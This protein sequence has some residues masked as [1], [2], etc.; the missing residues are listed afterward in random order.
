MNLKNRLSS[1]S[2]SPPSRKKSVRLLIETGDGRS[3]SALLESGFLKH[4]LNLGA[5]IHVLTPGANHRPFVESYQ[6][7]GVRFSYLSVERAIAVR[8]PKLSRHE[9]HLARWFMMHGMRGVQ[10]WLWRHAGSRIAAAD[11]DFLRELVDEESPDCF[12]TAHLNQGF[13]RSLLGLCTRKGIPTVGN[14]FSWD[15]PFYPQ[16]VQ[17]DRLTCWSPVIRDKLVQFGG[18]SPESI[19]VTG[20]P[21]FDPYFDPKG[22]LTRQELCARMNLDPSRPIILFATLGQMRMFWDETGTFRAF[23]DALDQARIPG[24][25]QIILRLHPISVDHYFEEFR[26]RPDVVFSRYSR[27]CPGMRWWPSRE[28][29]YLAGNILR[30]CDVCI[31]PGST[32]T[33]EAAIFDK[34][35]VV[36]LFNPAMPD[37]YE[38]FFTINWLNK[39]FKF[40]IQ[41][42]T[43][44]VAGTASDLIESIRHALDDPSWLSEG[45]RRI[46]D[47]LLG[48]LDGRATERLAEIVVNTATRKRK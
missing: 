12:F 45:R 29:V 19:E 34:P 35:S 37:E 38:R 24:P 6:E 36:P 30:H 47:E 40:L 27:Y 15:H 26:S 13:G 16:R 7:A 48:P 10:R 11:A 42:D 41:E 32:M 31:S 39:H 4:C 20:A 8:Y 33:V 3:A 14:V 18:Y 22:I 43:V 17:P 25:P 21:V 23:L 44:G 2:T 9:T 1:L 5:E 46:R 28:E